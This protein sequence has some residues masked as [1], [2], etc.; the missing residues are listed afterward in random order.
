MSHDIGL[1]IGVE[2]DDGTP[3]RLRLGTSDD[4][5]ALRAGF[6]RL[7]PESTVARFFTGMPTLSGPFLDQ[8]LD[9]DE[10]RHV[11]IV[12]EDTS[13]MSDVDEHSMGLGIGV[14][15][16]FTSSTDATRADLAVAVIDEYHDR[17]IGRLLLDALIDHALD[18]GI[19]TWTATVLSVNTKMLRLLA[20]LGATPRS[21]PG[22]RTIVEL[23]IPLRRNPSGARI[24]SPISA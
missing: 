5:D 2:L 18:N 8:L 22:D 19:T 16:Y 12:A 21:D 13:R 10:S 24:S 20:S 3:L 4:R 1:P 7:T 17:G 6:E 9:V 23:E 14:A 11:A 15:R